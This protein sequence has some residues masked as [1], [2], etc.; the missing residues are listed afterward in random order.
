MSTDVQRAGMA[1]PLVKRHLT[2]GWWGL[3]LFL[4][5]GLALE[6]MHAFKARWYLDVPNQ[7]RRLML[8]LAHAHGTL[9]SLVNL[10]NAFTLYVQRLPEN[11]RQRMASKLLMGATILLPGGFF[12]GGLIIWGGDPG[13]GIILVPIGALL[14][15]SSVAL[16]AMELRRAGEPLPPG[17]GRSAA[18]STQT[19]TLRGSH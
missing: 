11:A 14:L 5:F 17:A 7:T 3:L 16:T 8:T 10:G 12:A 6:E 2:I 19:E 4:S 1:M 15:A 13:L 18:A 9:L